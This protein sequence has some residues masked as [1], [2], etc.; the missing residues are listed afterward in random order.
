M[1]GGSKPIAAVFMMIAGS[2][3]ALGIYLTFLTATHPG[4]SWAPRGSL[5]SPL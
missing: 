1:T 5:V 3:F 2:Q 4:R